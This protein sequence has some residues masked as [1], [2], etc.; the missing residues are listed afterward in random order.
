VLPIQFLNNVLFMYMKQ[1][2]CLSHCSKFLILIS[3]RTL[4]FSMGTENTPP[5]SPGIPV[6]EGDDEMY[7]DEIGEEIPETEMGAECRKIS[8]MITM[9]MT[10]N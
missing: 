5:A 7:E 4:P 10:T 8:M 9:K 2:L 1:L 3:G 6:P